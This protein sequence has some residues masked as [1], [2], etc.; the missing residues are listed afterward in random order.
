VETVRAKQPDDAKG[1]TPP[2]DDARGGTP[3]RRHRLSGLA[4]ATASYL[5][6]ALLT[7]TFWQQ[8]FHRAPF[9][10]FIAASAVA[11]WAGG[12]WLGFGVALLGALTACVLVGDPTPEIVAASIVTVGIATLISYLTERSR[13]VSGEL[14]ETNALLNTVLDQAPIGI[15]LFDRQLRFIRLNDALAEIDGLPA[16]AH[17]GKTVSELLPRLDGTVQEALRHVLDTGESLSREVGGETPAAPGETRHWSLYAYALRQRGEIVGVGAVVEEVTGKIRAQAE[18]RQAKEA[19]EA[20]SAAKDRFLATLSH[21]LR[22]PLTPVLAIAS[23]LEEEKRLPTYVRQHLGM[24][25][26]NVE[27]EARL[28]DNLLDLTRIAQGKIELRPVSTDARPLLYHALR[29]CCQQDIDSGRVKVTT[30]LAAASHQVIADVPRLSQMFSNL[31]ANAMKFTPAGGSV[32]VSTGEEDGQLVVIVADS[33][34]G[35][36]PSRLAGIFD[37]FGEC[38]PAT[39]ARSGGLGLGLAISRAVVEQHGG[40]ISAASAGHGRGAT[41]TVRLPLET[42]AERGDPA[43]WDSPAAAAGDGGSDSPTAAAGDGGDGRGG[44]PSAELAIDGDG[45]CGAPSAEPAIGAGGLQGAA[46]GNGRQGRALRILLVEDHADTAT[47]MADLLSG[48]GHRVTV[49]SSVT[50]ALAAVER[51]AAPG[52]KPRLDLVISDLGLPDG[53]GQELMRDLSNRYG[54]KGI[55]LSGY[56]MD[57]DRERSLQAGFS[58]HLTKPVKV[59]VL[60]AA[61]TEVA[62]GG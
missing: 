5:A 18:L 47:A 45:R 52:G 37:A 54:L 51:L 27:L 4:V 55:A 29:S 20:A 19:A 11:A 12:F 2:P 25:R 32:E 39:T 33:G 44:P 38:D 16:E 59:R 34:I 60:R 15:A 35:I 7:W 3:L 22:T 36:E 41:F 1:G 48:L 24:M 17:L 43:G 42:A 6:A 46:P 14:D 57:E 50:A 28:I 21:E 49:A 56:G 9:P 58:R 62:G 10:L 31:L 30:D 8:A 23:V 13:E 26:R 61:I 40:T 53:N